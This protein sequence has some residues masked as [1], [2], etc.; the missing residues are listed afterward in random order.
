MERI[1]SYFE[2]EKSLDVLKLEAKQARYG[3]KLIVLL[4]GICAVAC[5]A[6]AFAEP[7]AD[8]FSEHFGGSSKD[9]DV[10]D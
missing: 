10:L 6:V 2:S 8:W 9:D 4:Y 1:K 5:A 7:I 3:A